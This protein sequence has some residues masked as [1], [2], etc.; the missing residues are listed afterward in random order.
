LVALNVRHIQLTLDWL[1]K[2]NAIQRPLSSLKKVFQKSHKVK[3]FGSGFAK[4]SAKL[5][6]QFAQFY[7]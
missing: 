3:S 1:W 2:A 4:L 7:H 6:P 5:N